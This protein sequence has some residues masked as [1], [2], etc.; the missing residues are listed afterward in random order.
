MWNYWGHTLFIS[1]IQLGTLM[2]LNWW[3]GVS[4]GCL[5]WDLSINPLVP[6]MHT[7]VHIPAHILNATCATCAMADDSSNTPPLLGCALPSRSCPSDPFEGVLGGIG[8]PQSSSMDTGPCVCLTPLFPSLSLSLPALKVND[9]QLLP[10][11]PEGCGAVRHTMHHSPCVCPVCQSVTGVRR[12]T[13]GCSSI[14][15]TWVT[16]TVR[17]ADGKNKKW[18]WLF[19]QVEADIE[20]Y[21]KEIK[22]YDFNVL[23]FNLQY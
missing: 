22:L 5:W 10:G 6:L 17:T 12:G 1:D 15:S 23:L 11:I 8:M 14:C 3:L 20:W 18:A 7:L 13:L 19:T 2:S 21:V 16:N 9:S 4:L